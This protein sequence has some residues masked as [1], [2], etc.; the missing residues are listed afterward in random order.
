MISLGADTQRAQK[1]DK[2]KRDALDLWSELRTE[3]L[4]KESG[5]AGRLEH[6]RQT[7]QEAAKQ[8]ESLQ[9]EIHNPRSVYY[10][11]S[12]PLQT[13]PIGPSAP[14]GVATLCSAMGR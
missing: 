3:M 2:R 9:A 13:P 10:D 5:S 4:I 7:S 1:F 14:S 12:A 11:P 6:A 8:A